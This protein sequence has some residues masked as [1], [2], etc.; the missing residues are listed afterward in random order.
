MSDEEM[1]VAIAESQGCKNVHRWSWKYRAS[2]PPDYNGSDDL[3]D[4]LNDLNAINNV[5][6]TI[7]ETMRDAFHD[8]L[9]VICMNVGRQFERGWFERMEISEDIGFCS[10]TCFHALTATA[11]Q[12]AEAY[13]RAIGRWKE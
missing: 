10:T 5:I 3:P 7:P 2:C 13:L 8:N 11:K 9:H 1:I 6:K 12:R 4:Y